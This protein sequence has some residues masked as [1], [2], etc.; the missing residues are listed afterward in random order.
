M[1]VLGTQQQSR[2]PNRCREARDPE[3]NAPL[4]SSEICDRRITFF[5]AVLHY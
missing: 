3:F 5:D 4:S 2:L 1:A